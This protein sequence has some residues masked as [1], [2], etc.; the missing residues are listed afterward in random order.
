LKTANSTCLKFL[1]SL[2]ASP[3]EQW[4][5]ELTPP[6]AEKIQKELGFETLKMYLG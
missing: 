1:I 6:V 4:P 2:T 3:Q 5:L